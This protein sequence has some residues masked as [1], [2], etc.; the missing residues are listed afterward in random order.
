[1]S[2]NQIKE[3]TLILLKSKL[4][5]LLSF[6]NTVA[7]KIKFLH[8]NY[9]NEN[10][11]GIHQLLNSQ[12]NTVTEFIDLIAEKIR[13][14]CDCPIETTSLNLQFDENTEISL[15]TI[16]QDY[17]KCNEEITSILNLSN[18]NKYQGCVNMLSS[19]IDK[20]ETLV[21]LLKN[22]L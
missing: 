22:T 10:F 14:I 21:Y 4:H 2:E 17:E 12:Y 7:A 16:I 11:I 13:I 20:Q 19:I 1:M 9:K 18:I 15:E 5:L 8:W 6:E 3:V